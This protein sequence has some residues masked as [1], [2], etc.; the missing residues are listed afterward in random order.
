MRKLFKKRDRQKDQRMLKPMEVD[1]DRIDAYI[2]KK[3]RLAD[4]KK[5]DVFVLLNLLFMT[6][7]MISM[8][9]FL[10]DG[11][12]AVSITGG[13]ITLIIGLIIFQM[14]KRYGVKIEEK[15]EKEEKEK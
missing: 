11:I 5:K 8:V 13:G 1:F 4:I 14:V 2:M 6:G 9:S 7:G 3:Y 10:Y 12:N 15:N